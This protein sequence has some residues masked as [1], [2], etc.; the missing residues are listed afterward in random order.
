MRFLGI[1]VLFCALASC[2]PPVLATPTPGEWLNH[3]AR[4]FSF[5]HPDGWRVEDDGSGQYVVL[6]PSTE[7]SR[8]KIEI[9][10]LGREVDAAESLLAWYEAYLRAAHGAPLPEI[11][12]LHE[13]AS[14]RPDGSQR[15][16]L[17]TTI[18]TE[19]GPAQ[20]VMVTHGRLVLSIGTY[21]HEE[22]ATEI[23]RRI[24]ESLEFAPNA[25]T[26]LDELRSAQNPG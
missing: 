19:M 24:A 9:A 13:E 11:R 5:Q 7:D 6:Y 3:P 4:F 21:T 1:V 2:Y 22:A 16:V 10:Y 26:T 15:R 12:V 8:R 23:V 20:T 17:H 14:P 25:P 18:V